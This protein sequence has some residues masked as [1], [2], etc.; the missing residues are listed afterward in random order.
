MI[1]LTKYCLPKLIIANFL[2]VPES[3]LIAQ[4]DS[5]FHPCL[6]PDSSITIGGSYIYGM[7]FEGSGINARFYYNTGEHFCLG[8]E[9]SYLTAKDKSLYDLNLIVHYIFD[10]KGIG[11][12]PVGG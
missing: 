5:I 2:F 7:R 10:I 11:I 9:F 6:F 4:N 8:L 1:R 12:Y 3:T